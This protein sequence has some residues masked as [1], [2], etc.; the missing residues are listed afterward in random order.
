MMPKRFIWLLLLAS[1]TSTI[2]LP[3][4]Q[5]ENNRTG[6][7]EA[8]AE[9]ENGE[10]DAQF[11][12]GQR[13]YEGEGVPQD[14]GEAVKWFRKAADLGNSKAQLMLGRCYYASEG[15]EKDYSEA[16]NWFRK[17]AE[18]GNA[19]AQCLLGR[20]YQTGVGVDADVMGAVKW[21]RQAAEQGD[22][23]AQLRLGECYSKG[24]GVPKDQA[25]AEKWYNKAAAQGNGPIKRKFGPVAPPSRNTVQSATMSFEEMQRVY[26]TQNPLWPI[27]L[28][29]NNL[30][31][32]THQIRWVR[33][34]LF[35][36][37]G[38]N[39]A[40]VPT[41]TN[42]AELDHNRKVWEALNWLEKQPRSKPITDHNG[43]ILPV[44]GE[45]AHLVEAH[46]WMAA[47]LAAAN[48]WAMLPTINAPGLSLEQ[49]LK[50]LEDARAQIAARL[51]RD[52]RI[53]LVTPGS[54]VCVVEYYDVG[55]L[56]GLAPLSLMGGWFATWAKVELAEPGTT[57]T[58]FVSVP[59]I[60]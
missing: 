49:S 35:G 40:W 16:V 18:Q 60:Q 52:G 43:R 25:E 23:N 6:F 5:A 57:Q 7:E 11:A 50:L 15:L 33:I 36:N 27:R 56:K 21:Y 41:G 47:D 10:S 26:L 3:A 22:A 38:A 48:E 54:K 58:G 30:S 31:G 46:G 28:A 4:H 29:T 45:T 55:A 9:S 13:Y 19:T 44:E 12:L 24:E 37:Q 14:F 1:L 17:A 2:R 51:L 20:C 8:K 39:P 34:M 32:D 53:I 59:G 42:A